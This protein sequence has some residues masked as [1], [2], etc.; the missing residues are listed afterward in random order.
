MKIDKILLS[1][2]ADEFFTDLI[3]FKEY[4]TNEEVQQAINKAREKEDYTNE[5]IYEELDKIGGGI[6]SFIFLGAIYD[7]NS[8]FTY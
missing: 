5:D 8:N 2:S 7:T 3:I 6:S 4:T 1:D